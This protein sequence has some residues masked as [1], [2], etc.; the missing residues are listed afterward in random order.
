MV[1]WAMF[2]KGQTYSLPI[3]IRGLDISDYTFNIQIVLM[4]N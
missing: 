1:L 2:S 3:P 4:E